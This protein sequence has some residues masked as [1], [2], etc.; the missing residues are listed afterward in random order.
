MATEYTTKTADFK[1]DIAEVIL[2]LIEVASDGEKDEKKLAYYDAVKT[3]VAD[4]I[5]GQSETGK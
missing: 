5:L 3:K 2:N 4:A 1:N